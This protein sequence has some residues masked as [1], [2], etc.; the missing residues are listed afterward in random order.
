MLRIVDNNEPPI[1]NISSEHANV[2][3]DR[4]LTD[5]PGN[6][7]VQQGGTG[8]VPMIKFASMVG[9]FLATN[10]SSQPGSLNLHP[11]PIDFVQTLFL[12]DELNVNTK[13]L[14]SVGTQEQAVK[15]SSSGPLF[16]GNGGDFEE[17]MV[18]LT[19]TARRSHVPSAKGRTGPLSEESRAAMKLLKDVGACW[20][21]R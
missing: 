17:I 13:D 16:V 8:F 6:E 2:D 21:C 4:G 14:T 9:S 18:D 3:L 11:I 5:Q 12:R 20:H 1:S 15:S 10:S 19:E 7:D